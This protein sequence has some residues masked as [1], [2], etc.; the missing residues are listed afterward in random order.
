MLP[1]LPLHSKEGDLRESLIPRNPD[2]RS[3]PSSFE[4]EAPL[5]SKPHPPRRPKARNTK[6]EPWLSKKTK[7]KILTTLA[8]FARATGNLGGPAT[9][10]LGLTS[11]VKFFGID[12]D[13]CETLL[14]VL[15]TFLSI[16]KI[17]CTI[18]ANRR[19]TA[20]FIESKVTGK[21]APKTIILDYQKVANE[22]KKHGATGLP[23]TIENSGIPYSQKFTYFNIGI[24]GFITLLTTNSI[25]GMGAYYV[26]SKL[27]G[28]AGVAGGIIATIGT[29]IAFRSRE[30]QKAMLQLGFMEAIKTHNPEAYKDWLMQTAESKKTISDS[31]LPT[32]CCRVKST[33]AH[34]VQKATYIPISSAYTQHFVT[35]ALMTLQFLKFLNISQ[36]EAI[37]IGTLFAF[38]S[39]P[40]SLIARSKK[41]YTTTFGKPELIIPL[42]DLSRRYQIPPG[43][44]QKA[45][46][47]LAD[48]SCRIKQPKMPLNCWHAVGK[49]NSNVAFYTDVTAQV[50]TF[51][52]LIFPLLI[53]AGI[54]SLI[55]E[56]T[57]ISTIIAIAVLTTFVYP[58]ARIG[59]QLTLLF[60]Y[61]PIAA[62]WNDNSPRSFFCS[63]EQ[64][65]IPTPSSTSTGSPTN[66]DPYTAQSE[67]LPTPTG[68]S[69]VL[70]AD[71]ETGGTSPYEPPTN[72]SGVYNMTKTTPTPRLPLVSTN[73]VLP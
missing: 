50:I 37:I 51:F 21:T 65:G 29:S 5:R 66:T 36:A 40:F 19:P 28:W 24:S 71:P 47:S 44:T 57:K 18:Y 56:N 59:G 15:L 13:L 2:T 48:E 67:S 72:G 64:D 12:S 58:M 32:W 52:K 62:D 54:L 8:L 7:I 63:T 42:E 35:Y 4:V 49:V 31:K 20:E 70:L 61:E 33:T 6:S 30:I 46:Q 26:L 43:V 14:N 25:K 38:L 16:N 9:I 69:T 73:L 1:T 41:L 53:S 3:T 17:T 10:H 39:T 22:L 45:R 11:M 27:T 55:P 23:D 60:K 68:F 34:N